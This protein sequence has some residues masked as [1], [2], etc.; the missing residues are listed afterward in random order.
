[1]SFLQ[2]WMIMAL[3]LA[4]LPVVIHLVHRNRHQSIPWAATMFLR[5]ANSMNKGMARLRYLMILLA[6]VAAVLALVFA[7]SRPLVS[8]KLSVL[9]MG[10]PDVTLVVLDRS[11]S[12]ESQDMQAGVSKRSAALTKLV[13]L[14]NQRGYG[15][16]LVLIDS[17]S[18]ALQELDSLEGLLEL[19][20]TQATATSSD[21]PA[22]LE[23]GLAY[24]KAN[25]V[26]RADVWICSDLR[27]KEWDI[28][29]GRWDS[30]RNSFREMGGVHQ[31]L[32]AYGESTP[33][34]IS[35]RLSNVSRRSVG[36]G[37]ELVM[38]VHLERDDANDSGDAATD[39][40]VFVEIEINAVRTVVEMELNSGQATLLGHRIPLDSSLH[41]GWGVARI[42][43]DSNPQDN[44]FY[45]VFA[46]APERKA[47]VVSEDR[48][49]AAG[50][51]L[52][53]GV[54]L[55]PS[56]RQSAEWIH[57]S[58]TDQIDWEDTA[59]IL[60]QAPLPEGA[61]AEKIRKFVGSG[62]VV[63]FF[64]P[65]QIQGNRFMGVEWSAW[66]GVEGES[67]RKLSWWRNDGDL[68]SHVGNGDPLPLSDLRVDRV[69]RLNGLPNSAPL[70]PLA[71]LAE[72]QILVAR[73]GT[74]T[75]G[76][77]FC[78]TLPSA[79]YSTMERDAI[80]YYVMLQRALLRGAESLS[81]T[82]HIEAGSEQA[83][84]LPFA[85]YESVAPVVSAPLPSQRPFT[86]GVYRQDEAWVA[87]NRS[88]QED[89]AETASGVAVDEL[90]AS[91][92]YE[93]ID[94]SIAD[95]SS[96]ASE[97]WRGFLYLMA[98]ALI[99]EALLCLPSKS[100][101]DG[102]PDRS[103]ATKTRERLA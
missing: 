26:G 36:E 96:L 74:D 34:N 95:S 28:E 42:P 91:L 90:F 52:S 61:N 62:R 57:P 4:A 14:L 19:P 44:E 69:C 27:A 6:R 53:L 72:D 38:D 48:G 93:R 103:R 12:M 68:L 2:P 67:A 40:E 39:R 29:G 13:G 78:A 63:L 92:P 50:F 41:S 71:R 64:P 32:L 37:A 24:L 84:A 56:L 31:F 100:A 81:P 15:S 7:V 94:E 5:R 47:V 54:P 65:Q 79:P 102:V 33:G 70:T 46:E 16:E 49:L 20:V 99:L 60:W 101:L 88:S 58:D 83:K 9:G 89:A 59:M 30:L 3:P 8:G 76:L 66:Q 75:G 17:A 10:R 86:S 87:I 1:M 85:D 98:G 23:T 51:R 25:E 18:D 45:F 73:M 97:V 35:V 21:I 55:E 43:E 11:A 80:A 22:L 77:Y 82:S